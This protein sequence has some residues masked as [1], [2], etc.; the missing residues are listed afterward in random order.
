MRR[1]S[2]F[3][4]ISALVGG[5]ATPA[6]QAAQKTQEADRLVQVYGP[7]CDRLGFTAGTDPWRNCVLQLSAKDDAPRYIYHGYYEYHSPYW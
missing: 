5:C 7:A 4:L 1:S 3:F 2:A 6:Q